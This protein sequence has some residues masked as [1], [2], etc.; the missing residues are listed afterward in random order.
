MAQA[1]E[2][3]VI[4]GWL[5]LD[6]DKGVGQVVSLPTPSDIEAKFELPSIVEYYSR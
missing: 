5:S 1:M 2:S 3:K 6:I 4:P